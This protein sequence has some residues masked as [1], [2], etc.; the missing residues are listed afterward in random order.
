MFNR[1]H[2]EHTVIAL[3]IQGALA[4]AVFFAREYAQV[5]YRIRARTGRTLA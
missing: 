5:E 2:L 3:V 4:T 1:T